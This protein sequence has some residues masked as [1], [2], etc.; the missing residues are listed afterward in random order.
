MKQ[1]EDLL[2]FLVRSLVDE[3]E[4]VEVSGTEDGSQVDFEVRVAEGD[5][6]RVI[7]RRGRTIN[8]VRTVLK[9]ASVN[10]EKKVSVELAE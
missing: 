5:V 6:G 7:G 1:L 10:A 2:L 8:A 4:K 3:P 9:A